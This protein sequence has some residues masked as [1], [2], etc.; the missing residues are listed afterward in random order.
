MQQ[1]LGSRLFPQKTAEKLAGRLNFTVCLA[2]DKVGRAFLKPVYAEANQ[3]TYG[4]QLS[5]LGDQA[6]R[7]LVAYLLL[8]PE[9]TIQALGAPRRHVITWTDA[10]GPSRRLAGFIW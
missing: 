8:R 2:A 3:P 7:W 1:I 9:R 4:E 5:I 6:L 10:E